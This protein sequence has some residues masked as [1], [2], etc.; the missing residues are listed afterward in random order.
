MPAAQIDRAT[1]WKQYPSPEEGSGWVLANRN[2]QAI[3][4]YNPG[5]TTEDTFPVVT[6][7]RLTTGEPVD[8]QLYNLLPDRPQRPHRSPGRAELRAVCWTRSRSRTARV[9]IPSAA[10][11][12][13]TG[14][15]LTGC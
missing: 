9:S 10:S 5:G 8:C 4:G 7:V 1:N 3:P 12:A 6:A 2:Y 11:G 15:L 14:R 13:A